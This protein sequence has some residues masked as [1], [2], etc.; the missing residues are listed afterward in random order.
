MTSFFEHILFQAK[1][2][3]NAPAIM[4][5]RVVVTY[6]ELVNRVR[7]VMKYLSEQ[8]V[9]SGQTLA[10][11][12]QDPTAHCSAM[13]GAMASGVA[14][15]SV[16]GAKPSLPKKLGVDAMLSDHPV[17]VEGGLKVLTVAPTWLKD[18]QFGDVGFT[19][20]GMSRD[21]VARIITTSG[22]TGEQKAVPF[23][24]EQLVERVYAQIVG[25]RPLA[26]PSKT[27]GM[28]GVASGA[29][30]TNMML[31]LMTGG[32]LMLVPGMAQLSRLSSLY[33]MDRI[34]ASTAQLIAMLR[35][36]ENDSADFSGVKSMVVGGSHIPRSVAKRARVICRNII[37]LYGATEVGVVATAPT[38]FLV[39]HQSAVGFVAPGV[40]LEI[41]DEA[42]KA[43]GAEQEGVIRVKA[44]GAATRYLNDEKASRAVF[45]DG[46]FYPG[47][48]GS[49]SPDGLLFV[50]G[51]VAERINAG[52]VKVAP[53]VI[54]DVIS[55]RPE[56]SDVAAF[57]H[58]NA[59]GISEIAVAI[60]PHEKIDRANFNRSELRQYF[61]K[62]LRERT[63]R[64][65]IIV[66]EIPRSEQ[67]KIDRAKL[68][69]MAKAQFAASG[70]QAALV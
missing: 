8:G 64:R 21:A 38:S 26:G 10:L 7:G 22:T 24:E 52:G 32:T 15:L 31:V 58:V 17:T 70:A 45:R 3:P 50:T 30:F 43:L 47:D 20:G 62:Q 5:A 39:N 29:G 33:K 56:I 60:V 44:P 54:E 35:Q 23:T 27:L 61:Q 55:S 42:G 48:T 2:H 16:V 59:E 69:R 49:L 41:V 1:S 19:P 57:E 6:E 51:R 28:M 11:N 67:G 53:S 13:I 4:T 46:W 12:M 66:K 68:Q 37:C 9:K 14:T 25:L 65:W 18:Q 63:P 34:L 40:K 36:Q